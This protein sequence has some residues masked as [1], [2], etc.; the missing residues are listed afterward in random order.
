MDIL[1]EA[2]LR[3]FPES[4]RNSIGR[5]ILSLNVGAVAFDRECCI[6]NGTSRKMAEVH[7][8]AFR[9]SVSRML[10]CSLLDSMI[11]R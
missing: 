5:P 2:W 1:A 10:H 3:G 4:G 9:R 6:H 8:I 11:R 7:S